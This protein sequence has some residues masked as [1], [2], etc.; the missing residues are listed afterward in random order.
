MFSLDRPRARQH[1]R[2]QKTLFEGIDK[3]EAID[4][5]TVRVTLKSPDGRFVSRWPGAMR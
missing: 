2:A 4:L 5:Q 3:V 1:Q